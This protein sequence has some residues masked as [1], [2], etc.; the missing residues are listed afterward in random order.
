M[1]L[2]QH[3]T[4]KRQDEFDLLEDALS[5]GWCDGIILGAGEEVPASLYQTAE[6][7]LGHGAEIL[8]DPQVYILS[9]P[10]RNIKR[11]DRY[12]WFPRHGN[13]FRL[14]P[15]EVIQI[16]RAAINFQRELGSTALIAPTPIL[17]DI[18]S[19]G[20][21][22]FHLFASQAAEEE[23]AGLPLFITLVIEE[24]LLGDWEQTRRLLDFITLYDVDGFYLILSHRVSGHPLRFDPGTLSRAGLLVSQLASEHNDYRVIVGY[25]GLNGFFFRSLGAEA[26]AS[27]WSNGLQRFHTSRWEPGGFG[28]Q[29]LQRYVSPR[30]FGNFL[31]VEHIVPLIEETNPPFDP[32]SVVTGLLGAE[33]IALSPDRYDEWTKAQFR[34]SHFE[35]CHALESGVPFGPLSNR[36]LDLMSLAEEGADVFASAREAVPIQWLHETGPRHLQIWIAAATEL[37]GELGI[38]I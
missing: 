7:V 13:L 14:S 36:I 25:A 38:S 29:P 24:H 22:L 30:A 17:S 5:Q 20:A 1:F 11:L 2:I 4:G 32:E 27:G 9:I 19:S 15:T 16:V 37:A 18:D 31:V 35:T 28:T 10:N 26:F 8:L 21:A 3:G 6:T 12:E 23:R 34:R 33:L